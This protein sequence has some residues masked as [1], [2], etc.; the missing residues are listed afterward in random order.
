MANIIGTVA[1]NFAFISQYDGQFGPTMSLQLL[2]NSARNLTNATDVDKVALMF[3]LIQDF[4]GNACLDISFQNVC[5]FYRDTSWGGADG[6]FAGSR[7]WNW[8]VCAQFGT[9]QT[10]EDPKKQP[11]GSLLNQQFYLDQCDCMFGPDYDSSEDRLDQR[12]LDVRREYGALDIATTKVVYVNGVDDPW[13]GLGLLHQR[14]TNCENKVIYIP[15]AT[16]SQ[17]MVENRSDD[18]T[19]LISARNLIL[20][21]IVRFLGLCEY[22]KATGHDDYC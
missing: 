5:G 17:D 19:D 4:L 7:A 21:T 22:Y 15:G 9:Y 11:F 16:H 10:A 6:G 3:K 2:C 14:D 1:S 12:V 8:L 13:S 20:Q 18:S